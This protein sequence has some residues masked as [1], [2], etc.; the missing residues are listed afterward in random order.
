MSDHATI[1]EITCPV[2]GGHVFDGEKA[3]QGLY[4][5][6]KVNSTMELFGETKNIICGHIQA[7]CKK[8]EKVYDE[9]DYG[10][11]GDAWECK[12]CGTVNWPYTDFMREKEKI[13]SILRKYR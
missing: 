8:C 11:H 5:C 1:P 3:P 9:K 6:S 2:C 4:I 12:E 10:K 7:Y 13:M